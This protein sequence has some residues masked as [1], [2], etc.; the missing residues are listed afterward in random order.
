VTETAKPS[1]SRGGR[2][3]KV[4]AAGASP[5]APAPTLRIL[6]TR[7]LRGPNYWAR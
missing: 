4:K 7:V 1:K 2:A 5:V 3:K 6:E